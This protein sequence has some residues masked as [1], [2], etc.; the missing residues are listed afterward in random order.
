[1][2]LQNRSYP[3]PRRTYV[4]NFFQIIPDKQW[5]LPKIPVIF[6]LGVPASQLFDGKFPI[7]HHFFLKFFDIE[8]FTRISGN[9]FPPN[10]ATIEHIFL[11]IL[12][13]FLAITSKI[14]DSQV[15]LQKIPVIQIFF[16]KIS[17]SQ[18]FSRKFSYFNGIFLNVFT[19]TSR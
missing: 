16:R 8:E 10:F 7:V 4:N 13:R 14:P 2:S 11:K 12:D 17:A 5:F 6:H 3:R 15:F 1:M 18:S 19:E 9:D